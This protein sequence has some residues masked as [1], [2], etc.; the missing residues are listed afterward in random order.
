MR[1]LYTNDIPGATPTIRYYDKSLI[2]AKHQEE[3]ARFGDKQKRIIDW[4]TPRQIH[5]EPLERQDFPINASLFDPKMT[6]QKSMSLATTK[7]APEVTG[8]VTEGMNMSNSTV[9]SQ[10][11]LHSLQEKE[12]DRSPYFPHKYRDYDREYPNKWTGGREWK[13][14]AHMQLDLPPVGSQYFPK[15]S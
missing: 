6:R 9:L 1:S 3:I 11:G 7:K 12:I 5:Q 4:H 2:R 13:G 15:W 10:S 8:K 14:E